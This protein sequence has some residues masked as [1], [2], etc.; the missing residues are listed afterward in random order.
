MC[1]I[2]GIFK[3]KGEGAKPDTL[4]KMCDRLSHRGPDGEGQWLSKSGNLALGHR[5]LSIIDLSERGKQPMQDKSQRYTL[6]FNGEIYNYIELRED[7]IKLGHQFASDTDTEVLLSLYREYGKDCLQKIDGMFAFAIWD[8]QKEELFCARDRFGEKPFYYYADDNQL[9]FASEIKALWEA[10][11]GKSSQ[12]KMIYD[13]L[14]YGSIEDV[15]HQNRT[16]YQNIYSLEPAH[17]LKVSN[18][19]KLELENYWNLDGINT[20]HE[21]SLEEA[22]TRFYEL[23][24]QS[25][26]RRLRSD[27]PV[28]SSLSGGLDSS[29][30]VSLINQSKSSTQVQKTFSAR[31]PNFEKDE[32]IYIDKVLEK[33]N[34][35]ESH[36]VFPDEDS[37][38]ENLSVLFKYHDQ[39]FRSL[40]IAVQ[41]EVMK[42][43]KENGV[44]VLLDGQGA[45][46]Y[47]A[48]YDS[49]YYSY[50]N[51]LRLKN[52]IAY[53]HEINA[54]EKLKGRKFNQTGYKDLLKGKNSK[55]FDSL[56]RLKRKS[57]SNTHPYFRGIHPSLVKEFKGD[58]NPIFKPANLKEHI[59][60]SIQHKGL[61]ELLRYADSNSM[62]N[63]LEVRLPFLNHELVEFVYSLPDEYLIHE[64]WN[65]Y[66]L[67]ESMKAAVPEEILWRK[68]KIGYDTPQDKWLQNP[69]IKTE[70]SRAKE[71]LL[72]EKI[73]SRVEEKLDW[74]YLMLANYI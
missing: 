6:T 39:P 29:A 58:F 48:G 16:F 23:F 8:S 42:L 45:D 15:N 18:T 32:S 64:A 65:K 47:L 63:S 44:T 66:I 52:K 21:I 3:F 61:S 57:L 14:F 2:A 34:Q 36:A 26:N 55:L 17:F 12:A 70:I 43:A 28:G 30:I 50:Y 72:D 56:S 40:S 19:G 46:E 62:A 74:N 53:Q 27:V 20:N 22:K 71:R 25:V 4:K 69:K 67:R 60:S 10:G 59:K 5:R 38:A 68:E 35:V 11:I 54:Y 31:F 13:Y 33:L 51:Q 73:I 24:S 41:Y 7:L 9:V 37:V 49:F 1:G